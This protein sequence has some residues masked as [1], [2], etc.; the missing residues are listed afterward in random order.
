MILLLA[1]IYPSV[2]GEQDRDQ[3][4]R[5]AE[6]GSPRDVIEVALAHVVRNRA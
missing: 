1:P 5:M 2:C 6:D 4:S 3:Y